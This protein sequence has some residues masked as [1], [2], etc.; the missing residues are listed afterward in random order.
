MGRLPEAI[1]AVLTTR[2]SQQELTVRAAVSG[3][4]TLALQALALDPLVPDPATAVA[5]LDDAVVAHR[6][7][8]DR[9]AA[10]AVQR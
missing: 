8:L 4:R 9:F 2:A 5:I 10:D 6:P 7:L 1:A 3:D